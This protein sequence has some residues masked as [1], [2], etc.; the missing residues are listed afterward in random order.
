MKK[1][2]GIDGMSCGHCKSRLESVLMSINGVNNAQVSIESKNA[3]IQLSK[4][5]SN[6]KLEDAILDAGFDVTG[7]E[8]QE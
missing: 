8:E 6:E 3:I 2:I 7:I 5:V 1:I 4:T